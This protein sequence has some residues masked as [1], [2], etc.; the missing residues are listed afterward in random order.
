M[1]PFSLIH[2]V[3]R[4]ARCCPNKERI[5]KMKVRAI[6][7]V[8]C[9]SA[10]L[11]QA[12]VGQDLKPYQYVF[13]RPNSH[14]VSR[15][16]NVIIRPGRQI[17]PS[18]VANSSVIEVLGSKSGSHEGSIVLSDDGKTIVFNLR[19]PFAED[20]HVT[21]KV[22]D[23]IRGLDGASIRGASFDFYTSS[24]A[25]VEKE[26]Q[27]IQFF[28]G[29]PQEHLSSS[30]AS[31]SVVADT[32]PADFPPMRVDTVNNAAPGELFIGGFTGI[33]GTTL[34]ANYVAILDNAG[35]PL[36]YKR[37]GTGVNPFEYMFKVEPNGFYSYIERTPL[38]T[39]VKIVDSAFNLVDTYPKGNPAGAS[40]ADFLLLPNG[41]ALA[42]YF[43]V[44]IVDMSKIVKGGNPAAS[45]MGNLVQEF[46]LN[47]NIVFQ[48]SSFDYIPITDTYEDT[49]AASFDYS[50]ANGIELDSDG[51]FML[52]NRHLS[53]ITKIDRNTGEIIWRM[54]GK[55][56]QFTFINEHAENA[57]TY[58]SYMHNIRRLPNGNVI[59]F[60]NGNQ[61]KPQYSRVVEFK[62]D[63][64]NKTATMVWEYRHTPDIYASAQGSVQRLPNG[65]TLIGWG[66]ASL[67]GRAAITEV[68]PDRST[69][70]EMYFPTGYRSMRV[71]RLPWK[72]GTLAGSRTLFELLQGNT[73]SFNDTS[74]SGKTGVRIKLNS[75]TGTYYNSLSV[76]KYLTA[77]LKP[78]FTGRSPWMAPFHVSIVQ[79]GMASMDLDVF[80]DV[81]QFPGLPDPNTVRIF[82]R[83]TTGNGAFS[84]LQTSYNSVTNEISANTSHVGEFAFCWTDADSSA[85]PPLMLFPANRDS[86]N[87][88]LPVR[89][90]WNSRG[91]A[92]GYHLQ[93][94]LD[95]LFNVLVLNDSLLTGTGDTLKTVTSNS[96]FYWRVRARNYGQTSA[97]SPVRTF[98]TTLPYILVTS[99]N[100]KE[101][102]PRG[103]PWF[104]KWVSNIKDAVRIDLFKGVNRLLTIKDSVSNVGAFSWTI[105]SG[106]VPDSTYKVKVASVAD[107]TV[108][109]M[110]SAPFAIYSGATVVEGTESL[111][112]VFAL[113]QNY[114]NPFNPTTAISY[115]LPAPSGPEGSAVSRAT[116]RIYDMLGR[117]V[118]TLVNQI[119]TP[120]KQTVIWD[121]RN[122]RGESVSSGIYL[123][124]LQAGTSVMTKKL[125]LLK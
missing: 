94:A 54:G 72:P 40:H 38:A 22:L 125:V 19:A 10:V 107:S 85:S 29:N 104:I 103:L 23:G 63:E 55:R 75:V 111:P 5:E 20:E 87:Q 6:F 113:L 80:F 58:F 53:E 3:M 82:Q 106:F 90:S 121:G 97:W 48:W 31:A 34:Y 7:L 119:S 89:F 4:V 83:D 69:A 26:D 105:P 115:Q 122:D 71:Y 102:L 42:L 118:A 68:H 46:D 11:F 21:V 14:L 35:K 56:N 124:R 76:E 8:L 96:T 18:S 51:N 64:L 91:T 32:L 39:T 88:K 77:P 28:A 78:R 57:P 43:D 101:T 41:H 59:M 61:R 37:I 116:L 67:Q 70:F 84:E 79:F 110:S 36:A 50:H 25:A 114:P 86:V 17:D 2:F 66:D 74:R 93:V 109:G 44:K 123:Y 100:G 60:D 13:P 16:T 52:S 99:P 33:G 15:E 65:N 81:N 12:G 49:L 120:G 9:L 62:L 112:E 73:Y 24:S 27:T 117:E 95:S 108:S 1:S 98:T 47:K 30:E 92:T 45:V